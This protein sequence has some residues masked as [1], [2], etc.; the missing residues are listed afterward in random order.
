[1]KRFLVALFA[2][3]VGVGLTLDAAEAKRLGGGKSLGAQRSMDAPQKATPPAAAPQQQAAPGQAAP[4]PRSGMGRWLGPLAG[5]AAGLGLA[6]LFGDQLAPLMG[7]LALG[8]I[9]A[10]AVFL[11]MRLF[12]RRAQPQQG[13]LRYAGI[14]Q[15]TVAAPPPSQHVPAFGAAGA[16]AASGAKI[17]PGFNAEGFLRQAKKSFL[18]LQAAND[19]GNLDAIRDFVTDELFES[20]KQDVTARGPAPQQTD[21]V[22]LN[23]ELL[24]LVTEGADH[25]A[26]VRFSGMLREEGT[27]APTHFEE[28]WNLRKPADGSAGWLLAGIQ[29]AVT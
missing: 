1:M 21:V 3:F 11:L 27:G 29:Q 10:A 18:D 2:L 24:E 23:A 4:Q 15:E 9:V 20:L 16:P 28:I 19:A 22:T 12:G 26:S 7:A 6:A 14:G 25:W 5:L 17:P 13:N 8:L